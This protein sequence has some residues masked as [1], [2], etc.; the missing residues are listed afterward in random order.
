LGLASA[1]SPVPTFHIPSLKPLHNIKAASVR[2]LVSEHL[3]RMW[4]RR[5]QAVSPQRN[6]SGR[7]VYNDADVEKLRLLGVL[8][9]NGTAISQIANQETPSLLKLVNDL[10]VAGTTQP[11]IT[12]DDAEIKACLEAVRHFDAARLERL[13]DRAM[14]SL[15]ISGA[16]EIF[17]IRLLR[18]VGEAWSRGEITAS[19]EHFLSS[20]VR[21]YVARSV[22][23]MLIPSDAPR[24]IIATPDGQIHEFAAVIAAALAKKSGW[25]AT[26]LGPSLPPEEIASVCHQTNARALAL[27]IIYP[28]DD[29]HMTTQL[30]RLRELL[31]PP[32]PIL[33]GG[34]IASYRAALEEIDAT[35][36][37]DLSRL[38]EMLHELRTNSANR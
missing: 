13:M 18:A 30:R 36:I 1:Y 20:T 9:R 34:N 3:I 16:L 28:T 19:Q 21:D 31:P 37:P 7:R 6:A 8:T 5:Y 24:I 33:V 27:S 29:P 14:L 32:L 17:A 35:I 15:G 12:G 11:E 2:S 4:E 38:S 23:G 22:R 26:Y 10:P 25:Q